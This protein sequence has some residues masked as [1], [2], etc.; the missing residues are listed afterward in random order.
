MNLQR[1][2]ILGI[3]GL[4]LTLAACAESALRTTIIG[5]ESQ[6]KANVEESLK[7]LQ[8]T[9][10][11]P[12]TQS[13]VNTFYHKA[14]RNIKKALQPFG[15]FYSIV[16]SQIN[17]H[18]SKWY[19]TFHIKPG[20]RMPITAVSL[21]IVGAGGKDPAFMT[22]IK[23]FPVKVGGH[24]NIL[25]Y[26]EAKQQL[27]DLASQRGYFN[28]RM[29][30]NK[31]IINF[32]N[33]TAQIIIHFFTGKRYHFGHTLFNKTPFA[34]SFVRRYLVYKQG[35]LYNQKE[36]QE[37]QQALAN[38][39]YFTQVVVKPIPELARDGQV[40]IQVHMIPRKPRQYI[41][42]AGYGDQTGFRGT[43][44]VTFRRINKF[45][46]RFSAL[47]QAA[48]KFG[49]SSLTGTYTIPGPK[50]AKDHFS[51]AAGIGSLRFINSG[52][53]NKS[54]SAKLAATYSMGLGNWQQVVALTA[55]D[56]QYNLP[57]FNVPHT[58]AKLIYPSISWQI[59]K[60]DDTLRPNNGY[61][62]SVQLAGTPSFLTTKG[63]GGFFQFRARGSFLHT[64]MATH[65][66]LLVHA[67][68]GHT[69]IASLTRLPLSLQLFA[70]GPTSIRGFGYNSLGPSRNLII[71]SVELQQRVYKDF[72]L[73]IFID[74]GT[75][76]NT[77]NPFTS[78][79][80]LINNLSVGLGPSIVWLSPIGAIEVSLANPFSN[81]KQ[82]WK[83]W[84]LQFTMGPQL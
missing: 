24:L 28:A 6:V 81:A 21:Q 57:S 39:S 38:S 31:I 5:V 9:L 73:G 37:T 71:A 49:N 55:L 50:P 52:V 58:N 64:F 42:G 19:T 61:T 68:Y 62:L 13:E 12:L 75:I 53:L 16:R 65:T 54:D 41:I 40:P 35:A 20:K 25:K 83:K 78:F 82:R 1:Q 69:Q 84:V 14:P 22:L 59:L 43:L 56:E 33:Y 10:K 77:S 7:N 48:E 63:T 3:I 46:H 74:A 11:Y 26:N 32:N 70:G 2:L 80:Q 4:M 67:A 72:Y 17:K 27:F 23:K 45:G 18:D 66:R 51:L 29:V 15:Y 30:R 36:L 8:G 79:H 44:G 76:T 47:L 34:T 60:T